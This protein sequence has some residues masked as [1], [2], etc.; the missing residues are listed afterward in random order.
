MK[1]CV[2]RYGPEYV[3]AVY[4]SVLGI[5]SI[6]VYDNLQKTLWQAA[7]VLDVLHYP[8]TAAMPANKNVHTEYSHMYTLSD[9]AIANSDAPLNRRDKGA[10]Q[11]LMY[12]IFLPQELDSC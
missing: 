4:P 9:A 10:R 12:T 5:R 8:P 6:Q 7:A 2:A 1:I 3:C 11:D